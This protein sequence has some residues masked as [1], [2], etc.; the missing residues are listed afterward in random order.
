MKTHSFSAPLSSLLFSAQIASFAFA[1]V[2]L[3][4]A[5]APAAALASPN[6]NG[7]E[8]V[9]LQGGLDTSSPSRFVGSGAVRFVSPQ[10]NFGQKTGHLLRFDLPSSTSSVTFVFNAQDNLTQGFN[11]TFLRL[12]DNSLKVLESANGS[13]VNIS[14]F[15]KAGKDYPEVKNSEIL[16]VVFKTDIHN[17][18]QPMH[19]MIWA[20]FEAAPTE[21]NALFN[22]EADGIDLPGNGA[23]AYRGIILKNASVTVSR[24]SAPF[25]QD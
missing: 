25:F 14:S 17:D 22:S 21:S 19:N 2:P 20:G 8:V 9:V 23:G 1:A 4:V 7:D 13:S 3:F 12:A 11:I 6:L 16:S 18:E 24:L 10:T 15:F 5:L